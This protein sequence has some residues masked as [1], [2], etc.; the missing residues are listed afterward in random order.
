METFKIASRRRSLV[1][2]LSAPLV[3]AGE[4]YNSVQALTTNEAEFDDIH[5]DTRCTCFSRALA[6]R[7]QV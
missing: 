3:P 2:I 6:R 5:D 7:G 4:A 1:S